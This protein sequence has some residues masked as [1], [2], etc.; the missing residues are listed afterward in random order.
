[1]VVQY[2][3]IDEPNLYPGTFLTSESL[4]YMLK[5]DKMIMQDNLWMKVRIIRQHL[6]LLVLMYLATKR[7]KM[8]SVYT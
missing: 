1:M 4:K 3:Y 8:C 5:R 7:C 2:E 6:F